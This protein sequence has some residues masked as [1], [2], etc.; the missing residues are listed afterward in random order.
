MTQIPHVVLNFTVW[1]SG[2][3]K[4]FVKFQIKPPQQTSFDLPT[5]CTP[6]KLSVYSNYVPPPKSYFYIKQS[7]SQGA[8]NPGF[9]LHDSQV[10]HSI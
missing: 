4:N 2:I 8:N 5:S 3:M 9:H 10:E 6:T 7:E 1:I